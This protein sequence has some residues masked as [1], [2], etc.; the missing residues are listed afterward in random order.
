MLHY[1][2]FH[3]YDCI[4]IKIKKTEKYFT[5]VISLII[6]YFVLSVQ[7]G[8]RICMDSS[9]PLSYIRGHNF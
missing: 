8:Y 1:L 9:S 3:W 2:Y 4:K 5:I 7:T 6:T